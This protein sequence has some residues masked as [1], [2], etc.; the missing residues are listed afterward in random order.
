M[1]KK[2]A[3][4]EESLLRQMA[5]MLDR[6]KGMFPEG[7]LAT[8]DVPDNG[9]LDNSENDGNDNAALID[10]LKEARETISLL[11]GK[12]EQILAAP[13]VY[14][15]VIVACN[16]VNPEAFQ[17][18][19]H[20]W[21]YDKEHPYYQRVGKIVA[22]LNR[23]EGTVII[24]F[25]DEHRD[26]FLVG[27][28]NTGEG[29][30]AQFK[31]LGKSDGTFATVAVGDT[32]YEVGGIPGEDLKPGDKV[33]VD[34]QTKQ[35][36]DRT[37]VASAGI[38]AKIENVV[39]EDGT[40]EV[41]IGGEK[42]IVHAGLVPEN[43]FEEGDR[44]VLDS[45]QQI[46]IK[47]LDRAKDKKH[48][49]SQECNVSWDD[50]G[51]LQIAKDAI[52]EAIELPWKHPDIFAHYNKK[53]PKGVLFYGPPG[54]GKTLIGKATTHSLAGI[55]G[56]EA[57]GTGFIYVKGPEI[58]N[59]YVGNSEANIRE[60]FHRARRH[61]QKHG[62]PAI[63]FIDEAESILSERGTGRSS[64]VDK[65]IVPMFLSEMD[66]L[67]DNNCLVILATNRPKMLDPA[68]VREGRV[69]R[70]IMIPRPDIEAV[71]TIFDIHLRGIPIKGMKRDDLIARAT[72]DIFSANRK[73]YQIRNQN[74]PKEEMFFTFADV[75]T[76]SMIEGI[77]DQATSF[78]LKRDI[79]SG[80]KSGVRPAD[81]KEAIETIAQRHMR[82]NHK[83]DLEDYY[84]RN[85]LTESACQAVR[86]R[87]KH[88]GEKT[89]EAVAAPASPPEI[90]GQGQSK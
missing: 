11:E 10:A 83:F 74:N 2:R 40:I 44:V 26:V 21:I 3:S 58:L 17:V 79:Q 54:C 48:T 88:P 56:A 14:G 32:P 80:K 50:V 72:A 71:P 27:L 30:P 63:I 46:V 35:I 15:R 37:N 29:G 6:E 38:I 4:N 41:E 18:N 49:L 65:T 68:V 64:D 8:N 67:V 57:I 69:D 53:P 87:V 12:L 20:G 36:I 86:V 33:K 89:E 52:A 75:I 25:N 45:C 22:P 9:E 31:L 84:E 19:D 13:K 7:P 23:E 62:Y 77:C 1:A 76:G 85:H 42:K 51:G 28:P 78:A 24:E 34:L 61:H 5:E 59:M 39:D 43:P 47:C 73:I 60:L 66:G 81:V 16:N 70:H 90:Q 82:L 55:H